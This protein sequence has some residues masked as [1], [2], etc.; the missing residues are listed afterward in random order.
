MN[1][2]FNLSV[3]AAPILL[4]VIINLFAAVN[5]LAYEPYSY[6][7]SEKEEIYG[8]WINPEYGINWVPQKVI[9]YPDFT[10][11]RFLSVN[12]TD[13]GFTGSFKLLDRWTDSEGNI[14]YKMLWNLENMEWKMYELVRI[15]DS[16]K[17]LEYVF[18]EVD[19]P[20]EITSDH[21]NYRVYYRLQNRESLSRY[22]CMTG[23]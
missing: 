13:P 8:T 16:G 10:W 1:K 3:I 19:F 20:D 22:R 4:I 5:L 11:V 15:S 12:D 23:V 7:P 18:S 6:S 17:K 2:L 14:W 9:M 21:P